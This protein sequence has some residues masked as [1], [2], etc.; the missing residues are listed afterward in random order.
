[1]QRALRRW[2]FNPRPREEGDT[3][4]STS[5]P[6]SAR[7]SIHALAKRATCREHER[8]Q[9]IVVSIHAL[10]KRA[11]HLNRSHILVNLFQSTPS[12]RGRLPFMF[13]CGNHMVFQSTP[14]RRGRL[15]MLG[16]LHEEI[17]VSIHALAK[18][19]T[20]SP[21]KTITSFVFQ[22]TPSRRGRPPFWSRGNR[23][24]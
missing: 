23:G 11:T 18:R 19:A 14:S 24:W 22:S 16:G 13:E 9:S 17:G 15:P 8:M 1:M 5:L 3:T 7:V 6:S 12:R 10:A 21:V 4:K 20:P 2:S